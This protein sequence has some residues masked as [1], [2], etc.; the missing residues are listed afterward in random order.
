MTDNNTTQRL[1][2]EAVKRIAETVRTT[3]GPLGMD[4][5]MVDGGGNVIVTNDGATILREVDTAHPAAKMVVEVS[6]M[7]EANAYDGTTSTVVLASQL[8]ANSEGLFS[9]GLH[10][11]VIIKGYSTARNMAVECLSKMSIGTPYYD[12]VEV[13][14][15]LLFDIAKT[16][17]TGKSL[18]ASEEKVAKL[19]V[20]TIKTIGNARDVKTLAVPGGSLADSW[21]YNGVVLDKDFI[22]GGDEFRNWDNEDGVEILLLNGGLTEGKESANVSVQ[23][24][25]ANSYSQVQAMGRDKLLEAAKAVVNCGAGVVVCRDSVHDTAIAYLRKQG[26]SVVQRVPESTMRRL[27]NELMNTPIHMTPEPS[28]TTGI[29]HIDRVIHNDVPYLYVNS[30]AKE[31]MT[32]HRESTL[33]LKGATQSTLDEIQRGF[34]DALGVVSL[35]KNGDSIRFGG[36]STYVAIAAHLR[37]NA[38]EVGGRAQMAIEAFADALEAIPATI[39]ENAGYDPLDTVLAMRHKLPQFYGPDVENGG[40]RSMAGIYEPTSLIRSAIDGATEV[41]CAILRIDD[42]IGRRGAE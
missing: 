37:A 15:D 30:L 22:G 38:S 35:V 41:S 7:Q 14:D 13:K 11:N 10:P 5:M 12:G 27:S 31:C 32:T 21:L 4:K 28:S 39:A 24:S 9:K 8:L 23:V 34:D 16:A 33:I 2:I 17:I 19:C 26:I 40:V 3:L 18:E 29:G 1:N 42:V 6:K 25:D 20:E 36:G